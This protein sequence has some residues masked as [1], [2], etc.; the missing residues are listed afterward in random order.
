M[1]YSPKKWRQW[2]VAIF[3]LLS[4]FLAPGIF[5][6][7]VA[8]NWE[9][10]LPIIGFLFYSVVGVAGGHDYLT[11][12]ETAYILRSIEQFIGTAFFAIFCYFAFGKL[13][14]Y[15][16]YYTF[17]GEKQRRAQEESNRIRF[18]QGRQN[19]LT[20]DLIELYKAER[21]R[22]RRLILEMR[23]AFRNLKLEF[24]ALRAGKIDTSKKADSNDIAL[25]L[26]K[27]KAPPTRKRTTRSFKPR[28]SYKKQPPEF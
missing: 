20:L 17:E 16:P 6:L 19:A 7:F 23:D 26:F 10:I 1:T 15:I 28:A 22:D 25:D 5:M 12:E 21:E 27:I 9:I 24:E 18:Y 11:H 8:L 13:L 4:W 2:G 3:G 14:K